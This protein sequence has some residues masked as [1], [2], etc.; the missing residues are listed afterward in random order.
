MTHVFLTFSYATAIGHHP[1]EL[2]F[3]SPKPC[4]YVLMDYSN[5]HFGL[6]TTTVHTVHYIIVVEQPHACVVLLR[7]TPTGS[8]SSKDRPCME[9]LVGRHHHDHKAFSQFVTFRHI[10]E[11]TTNLP[12]MPVLATATATATAPA[13]YVEPKGSSTRWSRSARWSIK[14]MQ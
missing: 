12:L 2:A 7:P 8:C 5:L 13:N 9:V 6:R 14:L 11:V 10:L 1:M 4:I 3:K